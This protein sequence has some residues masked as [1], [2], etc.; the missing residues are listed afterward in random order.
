MILCEAFLPSAR[1]WFGHPL[2]FPIADAHYAMGF[3]LWRG[4]REARHLDRAVHFLEILEATRSPGY[5][6]WGW[7]YPFD[8]VTRNGVIKAGTPLVTTTP[9]RVY[10]AFGECIS[11]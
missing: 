3:A 7:G 5:R 1:R 8:W 10:E 2:R 4:D 9:F 11:P 6:H